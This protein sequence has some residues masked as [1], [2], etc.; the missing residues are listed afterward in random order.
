MSNGTLLPTPPD[1]AAEVFG[2]R[3]P[4]ARVFAERLASEG[5][6]RG[7]IGPREVERLWERHILNSAVLGEVI[8][9]RAKVIDVGSGAGLPGIP[10]AI[11]RPDV[12]VTL[13]EPMQRR[14]DWLELIVGE[15]ELP[16]D[17]VRGRAEDRSVR[18]SLPNANVVTARAVASL[19]KLS[20]WCLP[21]IKQGAALY[22]V[23]GASAYDEI[24]R[25]REAVARLGGGNPRVLTCGQG[26]LEQ[27]VRVVR[28]ERV[29]SRAT[30]GRQQQRT[31]RSR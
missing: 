10:L 19:D 13:L 18:D 29:G 8:P 6:L 17:V 20:S 7:M 3:L 24:E 26:K 5:V 23:K 28:I 9:E 21:L 15:L 12:R 22:A 25:D 30:G 31:R 27:S 2:A 14:V 16:I 1:S 4:I 11:A